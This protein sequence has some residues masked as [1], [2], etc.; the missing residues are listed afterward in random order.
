[1]VISPGTPTPLQAIPSTPSQLAQLAAEQFQPPPLPQQPS[2]GLP[3]PQSQLA[4]GNHREVQ[5]QAQASGPS[6]E[7]QIQDL[8]A[9]ITKVMQNQFGLK[10]K[11]QT[12]MYKTP[13]PAHYDQIAYP[14]RFKMPDFTK[15][16]GQDDTSTAGFA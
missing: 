12:Y 16:S 14:P 11:R 8:A 1:M 5:A 7:A 2:A 15:F 9:E 4:G 6:Q 3:I 10:P 13:Y